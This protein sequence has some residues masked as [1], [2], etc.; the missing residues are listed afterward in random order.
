M[1][2]FHFSEVSTTRAI[3]SY[4]HFTPTGFGKRIL[5]DD[6]SALH[7]AVGILSTSN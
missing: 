1:F 3:H 4:K 7:L 6:R 5:I 2:T